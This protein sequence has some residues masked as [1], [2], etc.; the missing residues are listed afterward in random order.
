M[1]Q[2]KLIFMT[3]RQIF[4]L[5]SI[6]TT[7]LVGLF[8]IFSLS[9]KAVGTNIFSVSPAANT[10]LVHR[11]NTAISF[12][13]ANTSPTPDL[14]YIRI[15]NTDGSLFASSG[16]SAGNNC[17]VSYNT[18]GTPV[19]LGAGSCNQILGSGITV[20]NISI[21]T[22]ATITISSLVVEYPTNSAT[23]TT[24]LAVFSSGDPLPA[25]PSQTGADKLVTSYN[26]KS[27]A[28]PDI[29]SQ[30]I[31]DDVGFTSFSGA[32]AG[33][34]TTIQ[35]ANPGFDQYFGVKVSNYG[36]TDM[37]GVNLNLTLDSTAANYFDNCILINPNVSYDN[38]IGVNTPASSNT[39]GVSIL[40]TASIPSFAG[41]VLGNDSSQ[42][43]IFACNRNSTTLPAGNY[44]N[45]TSQVTGYNLSWNTTSNA[46]VVNLPRTSS[47]LLDNSNNL[48][49]Q[50][51]IVSGLT[52]G[53][54]L[55][56]STIQYKIEVTNTSTTS[57]T[58]PTNIVDFVTSLNTG[59][60][61]NIAVN[62]VSAINSAECNGS[63]GSNVLNL[64]DVQ[65]A[66][67]ANANIGNT[68]R[69]IPI[70]AINPLQSVTIFYSA[71][72]NYTP[73]TQSINYNSPALLVD[74]SIPNISNGLAVN[75]STQTNT[76]TYGNPIATLTF[77]GNSLNVS[78]NINLYND[79]NLN[80]NISNIVLKN[81]VSNAQPINNQASGDQTTISSVKTISN[82]NSASTQ[83]NAPSGVEGIK[84]TNRNSNSAPRSSTDLKNKIETS[85]TDFNQTAGGLIRTGGDLN[86]VL[87]IIA[88]FSTLVLGSSLYLS[89]K[90]N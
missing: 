36:T 55:P 56:G 24:E 62:P 81:H 42:Y 78:N 88:I 34:F 73:N 11:T 48:S 6:F 75:Y 7:I 10:S 84:E 79:I 8:S 72:Y 28:D 29:F 5:L 76:L 25:A 23:S 33:T 13:V 65:N 45:F 43:Y 71:T 38:G 27:N 18:N 64:S 35:T 83:S 39:A 41:G 20:P 77:A 51:T 66:Y 50:K 22:S 54:I 60:I 32:P 16:F 67:S 44:G 3:G 69:V 4:S 37:I 47:V 26:I 59:T 89:L 12:V 68:M 46:T 53:E 85:N 9:V 86:Y 31:S 2:F 52:N 49:I 61:T 70:K 17:V 14:F 40:R 58:S 87:T 90:K 30:K 15:G 21:G 1:N 80:D 19:S 63:V 57:C 82:N 74:S